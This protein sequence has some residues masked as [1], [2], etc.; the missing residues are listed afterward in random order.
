MYCYRVNGGSDLV[1]NDKVTVEG[2]LINYN[3]NKIEIAMGGLFSYTDLLDTSA[4]VLA[5]DPE[6][7]VLSWEN[8]EG[9]TKY[10]VIVK[11]SENVE[12]INETIETNSYSL[13]SL[14]TGQFNAYVKA[15]G[16]Y[17]H[18]DSNLSAA[19]AIS[20]IQTT[21]D[22]I[23]EI[24]TVSSLGFSYEF[25][26]GTLESKTITFD[27]TSKRTEFSTS[28]QVWV[29]N[30]I[31]MTNEGNCADYSEPVRLYK[32]STVTISSET[33]FNKIQFNTNTAAY[34]TTLSNSI[35]EENTVDGK[36]VVVKFDSPKTSFEVTLSEGQVRMDSITVS[37][38]EDAHYEFDNIRMRF[39]A[40]V[41]SELYE[42][43]NLATAEVGFKVTDGTKTHN[44]NCTGK[45]AKDGDNY[46][47]MC[48][49]WN[50]STDVEFTSTVYFVIDGTTYYGQSTTYTVK[51]LAKKYVD[52]EDTLLAG[53]SEEDITALKAFAA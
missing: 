1:V 4:P 44:I 51:T 7:K 12:V 52:Y 13:T 36:I 18:N 6:E 53:Y 11:D 41:S 37:S 22:K 45:F 3:N 34:A 43:L 25:V 17:T 35:T 27:D 19:Y 33:S 29:E 21:E 14:G 50:I 47:I 20:N 28:K 9:A 46:F 15:I 16:D 2:N 48:S 5:Y 23:G 40:T 49:I 10:I 31:T 26:E 39:A 8:V 38:G 30:G 42:E 24:Q 32:N